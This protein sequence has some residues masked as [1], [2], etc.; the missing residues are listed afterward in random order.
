MVSKDFASHTVTPKESSEQFQNEFIQNIIELDNE[1][2]HK[3]REVPIKD[4][5]CSRDV[6]DQD[7]K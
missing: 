2:Y 3:E 6:T 1:P 7:V 5:I 4:T